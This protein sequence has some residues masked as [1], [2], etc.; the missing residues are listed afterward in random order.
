MVITHLLW[1][2]PP[3]MSALSMTASFSF[4]LECANVSTSSTT[5]MNL[6]FGK[7]LQGTT[8]SFLAFCC[9]PHLCS[10]SDNVSKN[11]SNTCP[12]ISLIQWPC[13]CCILASV[14][15]PLKSPLLKSCVT[16]AKNVL[17]FSWRR[18]FDLGKSALGQLLIRQCDTWVPRLALNL[19]DLLT[20]PSIFKRRRSD[21][22]RPHHP[23][24]LKTKNVP[25]G[26]KYFA[27]PHSL[28][29]CVQHQSSLR[30]LWDQE[31]NDAP[32]LLDHAFVGVPFQSFKGCSPVLTNFEL[33]NDVCHALHHPR[34]AKVDQFAPSFVSLASRSN[35]CVQ[36]P[37]RSCTALSAIPLDYDSPF[38]LD[39]W[40]LKARRRLSLLR[41]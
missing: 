15:L 10:N 16:L 22:S 30:F 11:F 28:H 41:T 14:S 13:T 9:F 2:A 31:E 21:I 6:H 20:F 34:N 39:S 19:V 25:V 38:G 23:T 4:E 37:S 7:R 17:F 8:F 33:V 32:E 26:G 3:A 40:L 27:R 12:A 29:P 35:S 5:G 18:I 24:I 1:R 36:T